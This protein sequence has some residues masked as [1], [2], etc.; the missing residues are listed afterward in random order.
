MFKRIG[1]LFLIKPE[2]SEENISIYKDLNFSNFIFFKEHFQGDFSSL[3]HI[4]KEKINSKIL[5]VDQEGGKVCRIEGGYA[6]PLEIAKRYKEE[7]EKVVREWA[8]EIATSLK[9]HSLNLNLAPCVDLADENTEEFLK[10][11]TFGKD[12]EVVKKLAYIFVIE[13]KKE[14]IFTCLKHFPGL[15]DIKIDP[16]EELPFKETLDKETLSPYE[17]LIAKEK[18]DFIMTTH[19]CISEID[20]NPATFS[21]QIVNI[22]RKKL[23]YKGAI[24]TDDLNMNALKYWELQERIILSLASGHNF[25]I[26]CGKFEN[27]IN[28]LEDIK[29]EIEK[30]AVLREKIKESWFI[31]DKIKV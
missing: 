24:L 21:S 30:S 22:L 12:L 15:K 31:F 26:Y 27:L 1:Q 9:K 10:G 2:I 11:R 16:H 14:G 18:V 7:G 4:L 29:G 8:R 25:L 5:A 6:S 20:S 3:I 19:L 13:H 23:D 17:Y 28:A